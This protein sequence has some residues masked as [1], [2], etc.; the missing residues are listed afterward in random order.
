MDWIQF[1]AFKN[2]LTVLVNKNSKF[3]LQNKT[4][5]WDL[6]FYI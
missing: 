2:D 4:K 5:D 3:Q 6:N 1:T